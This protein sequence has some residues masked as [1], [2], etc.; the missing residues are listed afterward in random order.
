[1]HQ[2][3]TRQQVCGN[4][5]S[6]SASPL[7][8]ISSEL[9]HSESLERDEPKASRPALHVEAYTI[10]W[11]CALSEEYL[12]ACS[13]LDTIERDFPIVVNDNNTY[14]FGQIQGHHVVIGCLPMGIIGTISASSVA[15][16]MS[17]SFPNLKFSLMVGIGGGA[18][19]LR[20]KRDIRLGD[21]VVSVPQGRQPGVVQLNFGKKLPNGLF[22]RRGHLNSPPAALLTAIQE[23]QRRQDDPNQPDRIAQ[24]MSRMSHMDGYQR[25]TKDRLYHSDYLHRELD[26]LETSKGPND[27]EEDEEE[28]GCQYCSDEGLVRRKERKSTRELVAHYGTIASDNVVLADAKARDRHSSDKDLNII[29]F[30]MEAAGLMNNLQCLVIRGICDYADSHKNDDWHK[31]AARVAAAYAKELLTV[32]RPQRVATMPSWVGDLDRRE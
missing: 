32:L 14:V 8:N 23:V 1:M 2:G 3:I 10:G 20:K 26:D 17:R 7:T 25:P 19:N 6:R 11:I 24:H 22:D 15:K 4:T 18:P 29:C 13:M 30:E 21:V 16:D 28:D 27:Y 5:A 31:Y 9:M 12:A